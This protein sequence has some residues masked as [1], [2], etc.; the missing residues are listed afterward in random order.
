MVEQMKKGAVIIDAVLNM[1]GCFES[2][3]NPQPMTN[4]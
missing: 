4:L 2:S 1:G 3:E